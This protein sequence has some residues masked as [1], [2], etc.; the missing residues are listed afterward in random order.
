MA[1]GHAAYK[2]YNTYNVVLWWGG[3]W[4]MSTQPGGSLAG[5][6]R[7]ACARHAWTF[8]DNVDNVDSGFQSL[9]KWGG[10]EDS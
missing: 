6:M 2:P 8:V 5:A 9:A 1:T 7:H 4:T 3:V 10:C